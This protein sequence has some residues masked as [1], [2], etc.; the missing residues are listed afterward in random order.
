MRQQRNLPTQFVPVENDV[1]RDQFYPILAAGDIY[2]LSEQ[3]EDYTVLWYLKLHVCNFILSND[4]FLY[5]F[6]DSRY[7]W[8]NTTYI[9]EIAIATS[10]RDSALYF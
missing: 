6:V 9:N 7:K 1:K 5:D 4:T 2:Y 8:M 3:Y 10:S